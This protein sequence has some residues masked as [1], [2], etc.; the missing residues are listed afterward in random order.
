MDTTERVS[1]ACARLCCAQRACSSA[2]PRPARVRALTAL[3]RRGSEVSARI[4]LRRR[5]APSRFEVAGAD[6]SNVT[7]VI[8]S[9]GERRPSPH[10][11]SLL[12]PKSPFA[13]IPPPAAPA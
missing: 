4:L 10:Y 8:V 9:H 7:V 2:Q 3:R 11:P 12:C 6:K 5:P 1:G 13:R